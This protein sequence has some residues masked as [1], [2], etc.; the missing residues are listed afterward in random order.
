[1]GV[2]GSALA[3]ETADVAL[4][5]DDL[6]RLAELVRLGRRA[7]RVIR[8]NIALS[9]VVKA[10]VLGLAVAGSA[11]LWAAVLADVGA[12]LLVVLHGMTL[13]SGSER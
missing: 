7:R 13:L 5:T 4:M 6:G 2:R 10:V 1:M 9:L 8:Q 11:T 12:S 3:L